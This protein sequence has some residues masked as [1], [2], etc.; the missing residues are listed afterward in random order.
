MLPGPRAAPGAVFME[1]DYERLVADL[2][3]ETARLL[4]HC[5][6]AWDDR[7]LSFHT[8]D[9]IVRTASAAQVREPLYAR[10]V[11]RWRRYAGFLAPLVTGLGM[12]T[13]P[14]SSATL[15]IP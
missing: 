2:S 15:R 4:A 8:G 13:N 14:I 10:S 6:L 11:G 1:I 3:G 5:G 7:C 12:E 9:R